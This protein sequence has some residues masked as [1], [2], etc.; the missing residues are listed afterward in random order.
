MKPCKYCG[1]ELEDEARFCLYCMQR[2]E[3]PLAIHINLPLPAFSKQK[4]SKAAKIMLM[5][6]MGFFGI[7]W[8][9]NLYYPETPIAPLLSSL[10][11]DTEST[12]PSSS[13][14][15]FSGEGSAS[16]APSQPESSRAEASQA[17]SQSASP[18]GSASE[19][20]SSP[21]ASNSR[22]SSPSSGPSSSGGSIPSPQKTPSPSKPQE[23]L[24][25]PR[26]FLED[27]LKKERK[28]MEEILPNMVWSDADLGEYSTV[29]IDQTYCGMLTPS[30]WEKEYRTNGSPFE[31]SALS[32]DCLKSIE[33]G[34]Y[35][36]TGQYHWKILECTQVPNGDG[37]SNYFFKLEFQQQLADT[38][39]MAHGIDTLAICK[40]VRAHFSQTATRVNVLPQYQ[41]FQ[42]NSG[43]ALYILIPYDLSGKRNDIPTNQKELEARLIEDIQP[44]MYSG[45]LYDLRFRETQ[46][47]G[48]ENKV[49]F[50][51]ELYVK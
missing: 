46:P 37:T 49:E 30:Q 4:T 40:N 7:F 51:F 25:A 17:P 21:A 42:Y 38:N 16:S 47:G 27:L 10:E 2:Q 12:S 19:K 14:P 26:E 24:M 35:G 6:L 31:V 45:C 23:K 18:S 1:H 36:M 20:P 22:P 32:R 43:Q 33:D 8:V 39:I 44:L 11:S 3:P 28:K 34:G 13:V 5:I 50:Y 41:E 15:V 9:S 48:Q 29:A